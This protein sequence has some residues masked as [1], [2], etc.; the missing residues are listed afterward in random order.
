MAAGT[1]GRHPAVG[2]IALRVRTL[3]LRDMPQFGDSGKQVLN[4]STIFSRLA[5]A[6]EVHR[7]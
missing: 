1:L 7:V 2:L 6:H 5:V 3:P 4:F